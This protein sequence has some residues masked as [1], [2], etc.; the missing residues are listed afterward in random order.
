MLEL[1]FAIY[2]HQW[3]KLSRTIIFTFNVILKFFILY[4]LANFGV[5]Q[6]VGK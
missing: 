6:V 3:F 4:E 2:Y 5:V 1:G